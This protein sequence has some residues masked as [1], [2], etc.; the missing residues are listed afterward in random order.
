MAAIIIDGKAIAAK[1]SEET[2]ENVSRL[3][4]AGI[5][6]CLAVVLAGENPASL[7]YV[8]GKQ[9]ALAEAGMECRDIRFP[10][11]VSEGELLSLIASLNADDKVHGILVQLPLPDHIQEAPVIGALDP[12]KD[13][14]CF[15]P[16]SLGKLL[17]GQSGF[18]PCTPHGVLV[19]LEEM[20]IPVSGC[21]VVIVGRP[22]IV[23]KPLALLLAQRNYNATVTICHT[24]TGTSRPIHAGLTYS[25]PRRESP[26]S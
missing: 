13:V 23:G 25:S 19:L 14:D 5:C 8:K 10:A 9:K 20:K 6:P 15:H 24:G 2:R 22:N 3:K 1:L 12:A 17:Q 4:Q 7:S 18:L 21:H 26:V 11:S 16:V